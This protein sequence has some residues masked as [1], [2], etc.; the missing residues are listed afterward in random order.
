MSSLGVHAGTVALI[1][2]CNLLGAH[3][4]IDADIYDAASRVA[5]S[6]KILLW[7]IFH[8]TGGVLVQGLVSALVVRL[9]LRR[10]ARLNTLP[11]WLFGWTTDFANFADDDDKT[12]VAVVLTDMDIDKKTLAYVGIV[13]DLGVGSKGEITR[14][15]LNDCERYLIPLDKAM[16]NQAFLP[17]SF[18]DHFNIDA[19]H[20]R[21]VTFEIASKSLPPPLGA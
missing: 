17:L 10:R 9:W 14:L 5:R 8:L 12:L 15:M 19:S 2:V 11:E 4:G 13:Y 18:F 6:G 3:Y 16:A 20:I 7:D 21:N 1:P